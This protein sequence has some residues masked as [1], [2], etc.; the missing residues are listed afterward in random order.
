MASSR[1][2]DNDVKRLVDSINNCL[3][4]LQDKNIGFDGNN[5]PIFAIFTRKDERNCLKLLKT[6]D[7]LCMIWEEP[8]IYYLWTE[9]TIDH[10]TGSTCLWFELK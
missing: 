5:I 7:S 9:K 3:E 2:F 8:F 1:S 6:I 10:K 4:E